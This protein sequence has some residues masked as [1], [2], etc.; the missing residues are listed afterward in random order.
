MVLDEITVAT[1]AGPTGSSSP[2]SVM[3]SGNGSAA[4]AQRSNAGIADREVGEVEIRGTSMMSSYLGQTPL[5]PG[6]A[7]SPPEIWA[8]SSTAAGGLRT[9]QRTDHR[10]RTQHLPHRD[11]TGCRSGQE[12]FVKVQWVAVGAGEKSVRSGL[13]IRGGVPWRRRGRGPQPGHS[14]G[15]IRVRHRARRRGVPDAGVTARTSSGKL[16][17]LEVKRQLETAKS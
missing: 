5:N 13:V 17:R 1:D 2:S 3:P 7:G 9:H 14:T 15:G 16:R 6:E 8:T 12:V 4:T 11:R 10:G